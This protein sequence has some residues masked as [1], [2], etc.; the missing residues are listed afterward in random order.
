MADASCPPSP[1]AI[2]PRLR[3]RM[4]ELVG[5]AMFAVLPLLAVLGVFG[6]ATSSRTA[7]RDGLAVEAK[8]PSKLRFEMKDRLDLHVRNTGPELLEHV[9]V[10]V[11]GQYLHGFSAVSFTPEA[12]RAYEIELEKLLPGETRLVSLELTAD[13]YGRHDG[14]VVVAAGATRLALPLTTLTFP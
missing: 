11:S 10:Q 8:F 9:S 5:I 13:S 14:E 12:T 3:M 6:P 2:A 1:P 4:V 7:A